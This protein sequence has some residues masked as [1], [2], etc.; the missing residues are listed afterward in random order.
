[1]TPERYQIIKQV[2]HQALERAPGERADF[3]ATACAGDSEL[4]TRVE[5]L[6]SADEQPGEFLHS[7]AY[8]VAAD[9]IMEGTSDS[10][11]GTRLGPYQILSLLGTGGMGEVYLAKD[12]RLG[13]RV[14]LKLLPEYLTDDESRV[15]RFKKEARAA[16]SLNHPSLV[17]IY[18]IEQAD[19]RFFIAMEFVE[20][21]TLRE[22]IQAGRLELDEGLRIAIETA[23][24]LA[25][26]HQIGIIHRDI[27]PENIM[28]NADGHV[29]ILDFG[30]AKQTQAPDEFDAAEDTRTVP[31]MIM[32]TTAYMSPE[33]ARGLIVD[34]RTD[35]W[36]LGIVLYEMISGSVPFR[37]STR[38]DVLV[39]I[40]DRELPPLTGV[41]YPAAR[42][43]LQRILSKTLARNPA[44][45]YQTA[46]ELAVELERVRETVKNSTP[47]A[48]NDT[49][50]H[51]LQKV[52]MRNPTLA[53]RR[54][55]A[56]LG[57]TGSHRCFW[58]SFVPV[59]AGSFKF[60][61]TCASFGGTQF[62][63]LDRSSEISRRK[64]L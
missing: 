49:A 54:R 32:G 15:R 56:G 5:A 42:D 22:L 57:D 36:S 37:G 26:A 17:T 45:R 34:A 59:K 8:E 35:I 29:K 46:E 20:G 23:G 61:F 43:E 11:A 10:L 55:A 60:G 3:L 63:L 2:F 50:R 33:Q 12:T 62:L 21:K 24:A 1:M 52:G 7:P 64:T 13:R 58:L 25:K 14:A 48:F 47:A 4:R 39:A 18:E 16:S 38:A 28:L 41:E 51:R 27:K 19:G 44:S 40:L 30:L 6:L 53:D 9:L 31:G